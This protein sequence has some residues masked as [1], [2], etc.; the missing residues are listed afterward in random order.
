MHAFRHTA[1]H[2]HVGILALL[3]LVFSALPFAALACHGKHPQL[4]AYI[5]THKDLLAASV[6]ARQLAKLPGTVRRHLERNL[7]VAGP[8]RLMNCHVVLT[9]NA[10]HQG[11]QE[12]ALLDVALYSGE[13]IAVIHSGERTDIYFPAKL[14][15]GA[16]SGAYWQ[17]PFQVRQ[18]A[19]LASMGFPSSFPHGAQL[20]VLHGPASTGD[21]QAAAA[22]EKS[23]STRT[24]SHRPRRRPPPSYASPAAISLHAARSTG[25]AMRWPW[26]TS[27]TTAATTCSSPMPTPRVFAAPPVAPTP[28][29]WQRHTATPTKPC[30]ASTAP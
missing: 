25:P 27:M 19:R 22:V 14:G 10:P 11:G 26:P 29:C 18:W 4:K 2:R 9:G 28:S 5:G 3:L 6:V 20:H 21:E 16:L 7:D 15:T 1:V 23:I 30:C 13:V 17:L 8:V 24:R 12:D